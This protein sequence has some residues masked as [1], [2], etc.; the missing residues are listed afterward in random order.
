MWRII[1]E[2]LALFLSPFALYLLFA[3]LFADADW[4]ENSWSRRHVSILTLAGLAL[5]LAGVLALGFYAPRRQGAYVPAHIE[6]GQLVPGHM[7]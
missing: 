7:E 6:N 4:R 1:L 3:Q 5:T 2:P